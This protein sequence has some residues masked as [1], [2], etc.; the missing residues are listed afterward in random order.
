MLFLLFFILINNQLFFLILK[1]F[2]IEY[3]KKNNRILFPYNKYLH[4]MK[5]TSARVKAHSLIDNDSKSVKRGSTKTQVSPIFEEGKQK[6]KINQYVLPRIKSKKLGEDGKLNNESEKNENTVASYSKNNTKKE[7]F[8]K[9]GLERI[10]FQFEEYGDYPDDS[11]QPS[12][13]FFK[14]LAIKPDLE[15][16]NQEK[17]KVSS[18]LQLYVP[19]TIVMNDLD[20]NYWVYTDINGYVTRIDET[21]ADVIEKFRSEEKD[22]NELIGVS[23]TPLMKDGRIDENRLELLNLEELEKCLFSKSGTQ[24]AIQRFVK[25]RGPKAFVCR[26]VWRRDKPPYIYILTNKAKY[27]EDIKNQKLK[28]VVNSRE[29]NSY[30]SF[31]STSGKHLEETMKYMVNIVKFVEAH[32]DI[33]FEELA[34]DFVKDEAGIWWFI[35]LKA[36]K[37]AN[38][39]KFRNEEGTVAYPQLDFFLNRLGG[40]EDYHQ[41]ITRKFDYQTKIKCKFCGVEYPNKKLKYKLTTKMILETEKMLE[42]VDLEKNK[43]NCLD[44]YDLKH[45]D[46]SMLYIPFRVCE[47]CYLLFETLHDIKNYQIKIGN[48]FKNPVNP[49]NFGFGF[50]SKEAESKK[51]VHLSEE[52]K[53]GADKKQQE[54]E[55]IE[56]ELN[57]NPSNINYE[58]SPLSR[59]KIELQQQNSS[60]L[61]QSVKMVEESKTNNKPF[62]LYRILIM[63]NDLFWSDKITIPDK[64]LFLLYTFLGNSYKVPIKKEDYT[65]DLDYSLINFMKIYHIICTE[66]E[67]FIDY[68]EKNRHMDIQLGYFEVS[69]EDSKKKEV[70][71][72]LKKEIV[73]EDPSIYDG[74]DTFVPFASVDLSLQGLKYGTNYRNML[75]GLL[76]KRDEPHYVGKL[77]CI[78]RIHKVKE[79]KD[80]KKYTLQQHFNLMIPPINFVASDE[81]PDYWIELVERQKLREEILNQILSIMKKHKVKYEKE[82]HKKELFQALE[83]LISHYSTGSL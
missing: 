76:F 46:Y 37:I 72:L 77:R 19:D 44:S 74:T 24:V 10:N 81:L 60:N 3:K 82:K 43:L 40:K 71:K 52:D 25:C 78:I 48:L 75:N 12:I 30:F 73:I 31:Y 8:N 34:G 70:K 13:F 45:N 38:I 15:K 51:N 22:D 29:Q 66:P 59:N 56:Y 68:V 42:H 27:H 26:S 23:K 20:L 32:S 18:K 5:L 21:D 58:S 17:G 64:D 7:Y 49:V 61:N 39:T 6:N 1:Y 2:E 69:E 36:M 33:V 53:E 83:N 50:Y 63:F 35:N 57:N 16:E 65:K 9:L 79:I 4:L 54:L 41:G 62:N 14:F 47:D 67:G 55:A 28:F 80:L 11:F